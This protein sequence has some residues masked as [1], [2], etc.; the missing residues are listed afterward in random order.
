M[1]QIADAI[2][3]RILAGSSSSPPTEMKTAVRQ[4]KIRVDI[5]IALLYTVIG[6]CGVLRPRSLE[7]YR[8]CFRCEDLLAVFFLPRLY[9]LTVIIRAM[10]VTIFD[11]T[12][13]AAATQSRSTGLFTSFDNIILYRYKYVKL[14][15]IF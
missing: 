11:Q 7:D 15:P 5:F 2:Y 6:R 3:N 14:V 10:V 1:A 4:M 8:L 12:F 13:K 9:S